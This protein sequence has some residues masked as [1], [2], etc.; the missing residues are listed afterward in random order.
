LILKFR[1]RQ[2]SRLFFS[3]IFILMLPALFLY[4]YVAYFSPL[5]EVVVP[6]VK[7]L[8]SMEA[9]V[10]LEAL[11]LK[12]QIAGQ[13]FDMRLTEGQVTSQRPEAGR[14]VKSGRV[15]SLL[16]S[17]GKRKVVVPNLLGRSKAQVEVVLAAKNLML[18]TV[19]GEVVQELE[20]GQVLTQ[21]PLPGEEVEIGTLVDITVSASEEEKE[22][23][24]VWPWY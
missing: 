2:A 19:E 23:G 12:P 6:E 15:V 17:S 20:P 14:K 5:P 18:G 13:V 9:M 7:G 8:A 21:A 3:I 22:K 1:L 16:T 4:L 24:G 11:G 10:K